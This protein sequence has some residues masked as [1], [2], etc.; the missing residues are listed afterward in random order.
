VIRGSTCPTFC[1]G[2]EQKKQAGLFGFGP[3]LF[4]FKLHS[5]I[6]KVFDNI[7]ATNLT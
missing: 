6:P 5:F 2:S 3:S 7:N 1:L 4:K